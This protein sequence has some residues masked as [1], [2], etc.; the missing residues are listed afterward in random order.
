L[1]KQLAAGLS[2]HGIASLRFDKRGMH[3]NR[4]ELPKDIA[5]Y[6]DFFAWENFV[7]DVACA[8]RF[9]REQPEIRADRVG[10]LGHSEGGMLALAADDPLRAEQIEPAALVLAS[11]PGRTMEAVIHDQL[12]RLLTR[13]KANERE[14]QFYLDENAR[15]AKVILE[16]GRVPEDVPSGLKALYPE[17]LGKFLKSNFAVS[18]P[19]WRRD[20]AGRRW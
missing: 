7:G 18:P 17:Y 6:G 11:T 4:D 14:T 15:I 12:A 16:T 19:S 10:I 5:D 20:S 2:R 1:L 9:L 3:A 13:Q 8:F